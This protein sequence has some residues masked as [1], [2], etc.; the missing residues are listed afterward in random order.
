MTSS[1][2][3]VRRGLWIAAVLAAAVLLRSNAGAESSAGEPQALLVELHL[4]CLLVSEAFPAYEASS[5]LYLPLGELSRQLGLAIDVDA[6]R[7]TAHGF[8][9]REGRGF[10]LDLARRRVVSDGRIVDFDSTAVMVQDNDL[11]VDLHTLEACL[12]VD[13]EP[14]LADGVLSLHSREPFP[15]ELRRARELHAPRAASWEADSESTLPSASNPYSLIGVPFVDQT[16]R[17]IVTGVRGRS[18]ARVTES[19]THLSGDLLF[20]QAHVYALTRSGW[21]GGDLRASLARRDPDGGLLAGLRAT[22]VAVGELPDPGAEFVTVPRSAS[23]VLISSMPLQRPAHFDRQTFTG[24]LPQDWDVEL[25]RNDLLMAYQ[26]SGPD[27]TYRFDDVPLDVGLNEFRLVFY[28]PHGERRVESQTYNVDASMPR[29]RTFD[30]RLT[31]SDPRLGPPRAHLETELGLSRTLAGTVGLVAVRDSGTTRP[32]AEAGLQWV[33]GRLFNDLHAVADR[34]GGAVGQI[35]SRLRWAGFGFD[36]RHVR[37]HRFDSEAL[38]RSGTALRSQTALSAQW[39]LKL[40]VLSGMPVRLEASPSWAEGGV[41]ARQW[42]TSIR[43]SWRGLSASES[44]V[45]SSFA[46]NPSVSRTH[47]LDMSLRTR[48]FTGRADAEDSQ[49]GETRPRSGHV[50]VERN[51]SRAMVGGVGVGR[52]LGE[53]QYR[54]YVGAQRGEVGFSFDAQV[55]ARSGVSCRVALNVGFR[56]DPRDGRWLSSAQPVAGTGAASALVFLD[57][58]GNGKR[59]PGEP[60]ISDAVVLTPGVGMAARTGADGRATLAGLPSDQRTDILVAP[61]SLED[62]TWTP[63]HAGVRLLSRAGRTAIVDLPVTISGEVTGTVRLRPLASVRRT[64]GLH[65][66][67]GV[68]LQLTDDA[69]R[70]ARTTRSAFDGFFDLTD[71]PPGRYRLELSPTSAQRFALAPR[72]IVIGV[73][74]TIVDGVDVI[75]EPRVTPVA[76]D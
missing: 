35:A 36:A 6:S 71:V 13:A 66:M 30:Y 37:L 2:G 48:R 62:P 46:G 74:G 61:E 8:V 15:F 56:R 31:A 17:S 24:S 53:M 14:R 27:G 41:D 64:G 11:F 25:Y 69:G 40:P 1:A 12:P 33:G 32:Y 19:E 49:L 45:A 3:R 42:T 65:G 5:R 7:G 60:P 63:S 26:Q 52:D 54:S 16:V 58:D 75:V 51:F 22:E 29:P 43:T 18:T 20:A 21:N 59:D 44:N 67:G 70:A 68:S 34:H 9:L 72:P 73:T 47:R 55:G 4:D 10:D 50:S 23:G 38:P 39:T 76:G 57:Q 28:G